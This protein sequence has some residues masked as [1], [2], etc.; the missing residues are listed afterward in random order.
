MKVRS[1]SHVGLTV[2]DFEQAVRWYSDMFG[3]KL[4]SEQVLTDEQ[5]A[6][7]WPLY[8]VDKTMVRLGFLRTP[9]GGV[10]EIF[11]FSNKVTP[12]HTVWNKPGATHFTLDVKNVDKW[13]GNL[14]SKGVEFLIEPQ[15]TDGNHW[16][17]LKD[18]DGNL[19][20]LIDLK[21]NYFIIRVLG[22]LAGKFMARGKFKDYYMEKSYEG[23]L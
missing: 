13:Y 16:V 12:E 10:V 8:K 18:P 5:V 14:R 6:K 20:E 21:A 11:E 17:F 22:G 19:V 4:I 2:S 3:F 7:L 1:F 15:V 9:K 23:K